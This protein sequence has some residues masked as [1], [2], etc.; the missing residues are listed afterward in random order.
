[1]EV[2][3]K[4]NILT[5]SISQKSK[6]HN[7]SCALYGSHFCILDQLFNAGEQFHLILQVQIC[8]FCCL[9]FPYLTRQS[10]LVIGICE[11]VTLSSKPVFYFPLIL[12]FQLFLTSASLCIDSG[13]VHLIQL[14]NYSYK[15]RRKAKNKH[16]LRRIKVR[17][18]YRKN[19]VNNLSAILKIVNKIP[20]FCSL[21]IR[22]QSAL[23]F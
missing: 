23:F 1:M 3:N 9:T 7:V 15:K 21:Q 19:S 16:H 12:L 5:S 11:L 13:M 4:T 17:V 22:I 8:F 10:E 2:H 18:I 20:L 14:V 6:L